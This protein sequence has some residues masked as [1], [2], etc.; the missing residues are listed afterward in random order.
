MANHKSALKRHRQSLK[1]Q[2]RNKSSKSS[3]KT[4]VKKINAAVDEKNNDTA[5]AL[6]KDATRF[7]NKTASKGIIHKNNAS[8]KISK[9]TRKV[10]SL[11][12]ASS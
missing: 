4:L 10:N 11:Q 7:I 3:I 6:L 12:S 1:R 8:R 9:L 5:S 2:E